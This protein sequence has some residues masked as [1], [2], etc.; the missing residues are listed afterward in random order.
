[1]V[2]HPLKGQYFVIRNWN[3]FLD[4]GQDDQLAHFLCLSCIFSMH[5]CCP[6][7]VSVQKGQALTVKSKNN[8]RQREREN[9]RE[10]ISEMVSVFCAACAEAKHVPGVGSVCGLTHG[11]SSSYF[12]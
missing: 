11:A 9:E 5:V 7:R 1:M 4:V 12:P 8:Y 3:L 2:L 10:G 6:V